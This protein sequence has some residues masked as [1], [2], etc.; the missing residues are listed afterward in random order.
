ME[1]MHE[2]SRKVGIAIDSLMSRRAIEEA[3]AQKVAEENARVDERI[4]DAWGGS[5]EVMRGEVQGELMHGEVQGELMHGEVQGEVRGRRCMGRFEGGDAWGGSGEVRG[6][7][8]W[9]GSREPMHGEVRSLSIGVSASNDPD[10]RDSSTPNDGRGWRMQKLLKMQNANWMRLLKLDAHVKLESVFDSLMSTHAEACALIFEL[11]IRKHKASS[12]IFFIAKCGVATNLFSF[13]VVLFFGI[14]QMK[15]V[16]D[17]SPL[18]VCIT[19]TSNGMKRV[20]SM[21][22]LHLMWALSIVMEERSFKQAQ[23][24]CELEPSS[25]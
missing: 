8:A 13:S 15:Q 1:N 11:F 6:G 17:G 18:L 12:L 25:S 23:G 24:S 2:T 5:R 4:A 22:N 7:D 20:E 9:G 14:I 3:A 16:L 10:L 21:L 19:Q